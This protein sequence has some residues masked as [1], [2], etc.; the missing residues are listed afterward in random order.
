MDT[1]M[2]IPTRP[3]VPEPEPTKATR[4]VP[5]LPTELWLL[6]FRFAT[7]TH[8]STSAPQY[9]PFQ[10][11]PDTAAALS[12]A[13]LRDKRALML[14]CTQWRALVHDMLYEDIRIGPGLSSLHAA[15]CE[16]PVVLIAKDDNPPRAQRHRVRRAVLPYA[17][18]A[19]PTREAPPALALLALLP[20]LEVLVRPPPNPSFYF[21]FHHHYDYHHRHHRPRP[22]PP[23]PRFEF[24]TTTPALPALRRLEWAFD[25]TG[26]AARA[27][28]INALDDVLRAAPALHDLV[29][30]GPMPLAALRQHHDPRLRLRALRTLR[31][32]AGAGAC[33]FVSRQTTYWALPALENVV[34]AGAA[35]AEVLEPLWETFGGLVRALEVQ[36]GGAGGT[37]TG[38]RGGGDAPLSMMDVGKIVGA[39]PR[40]EELNVR[41]SAEDFENS[42]GDSSQVDSVG[43]PAPVHRT[44]ACAHDKLQRLGVCVDAGGWTAETWTAVIEYVGQFV[45][46]CP[47]LRCVA[48]YVQNMGVTAQNAQ[49]HRLREKVMSNG[50]ELLLRSVHT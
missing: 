6:I 5:R 33:P 39:C 15:L 34:V 27:G 9:E 4:Y 13:A 29:L 31:L 47:A 45:K 10:P 2:L 25:A 35:H 21:H 14:V 38:V 23:L 43:A 7:S 8:T 48:L 22:L 18:T 19:T 17:H 28:G 41:M 11:S 20:H 37:G 32:H 50:R 16:P 46:G 26:A 1:A 40:L 42:P 44:W 49:F 30:V 24:S 12:D 3:T 36:V